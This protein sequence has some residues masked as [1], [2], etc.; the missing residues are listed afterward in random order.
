MSFFLGPVKHK[1]HSAPVIVL[2]DSSDSDTSVSER[3][4]KSKKQSVSFSS[5]VVLN[6]Y[7]LSVSNTHP[8]LSTLKVHIP[9]NQ[10]TVSSPSSSSSINRNTKGKRPI[11]LSHFATIKKRVENNKKRTHSSDSSDEDFFVP[12]V[13]A[14]FSLKSP[15]SLKLRKSGNYWQSIIEHSREASSHTN[16][17]LS[18][19]GNIALSSTPKDLSPKKKG[20][21]SHK[22]SPTKSLKHKKTSPNKAPPIQN[23]SSLLGT[24]NSKISVNTENEFH[25][26]ST[27]NHLIDTGTCESV[28]SISELGCDIMIDHPPLTK[29]PSKVKD[30]EDD[31]LSV[32]S[33]SSLT[34][35]STNGSTIQQPVKPTRGRP[36]KRRYHHQPQK[37]LG[38][39][40]IKSTICFEKLFSF[41]PPNLIVVDGDLHPAHSLSL[42]NVD[43]IPDNHPI[44][45]WKLGKSAPKPRKKSNSQSKDDVDP[46]YQ[47]P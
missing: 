36:P 29:K 26:G 28:T 42:K 4:P 17:T 34:T 11:A 19:N 41:H 13:D 15:L 44:H 2:S 39:K 24:L 25:T 33:G 8:P 5:S 16:S 30:N 38:I 3:P 6:K 14:S 10:V 37:P 9:L 22:K 12:E 27:I 23:P 1:R 40:N 43:L 20:S 35:S 45:T 31:T 18:S 46:E 47:P 32:M 7:P 21:N